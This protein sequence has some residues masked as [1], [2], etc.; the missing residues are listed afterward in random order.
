MTLDAQE[1]RIIDIIDRVG[2]AVMNI[3][4][5]ESDQDPRWFSFTVGASDPRVAGPLRSVCI[6]RPCGGRI[7]FKNWHTQRQEFCSFARTS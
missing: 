1:V 7:A 6:G 3:G 4:P 2:W 5:N